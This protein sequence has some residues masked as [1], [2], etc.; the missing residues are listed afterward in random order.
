MTMG[1]REVVKKALDKKKL[2]SM[3]CG[4][5]KLVISMVEKE[6]WIK[7][8]EKGEKPKLWI[9]RREHIALNRFEE[10]AISLRRNK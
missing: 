10:Q 4:G 3:S 9:Y 5:I 2:Y 1:L 6:F 8:I 7:L